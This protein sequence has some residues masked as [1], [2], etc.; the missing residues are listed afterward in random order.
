MSEWDDLEKEARSLSANRGPRCGVSLL[1]DDIAEEFGPEARDSVIRT[2][3]NHRLTTTS[4]RKALGMRVTEFM[5]LPSSYSIQRHRSSR[6]GC[7]G[8]AS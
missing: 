5:D 1:L 4:I 2:L 6:C 7:K 3:D 8:D